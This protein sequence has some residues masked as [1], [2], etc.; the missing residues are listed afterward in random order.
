[1]SRNH[2]TVYRDGWVH[3][4]ALTQDGDVVRA[5]PGYATWEGDW[6]STGWEPVEDATV[7]V[8][9]RQLLR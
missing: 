7:T 4:Y 8:A 2:V 3:H 1:M 9:I 6:P 5:N